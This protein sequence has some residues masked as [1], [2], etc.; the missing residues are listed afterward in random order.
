MKR[1]VLLVYYVSLSFKNS[2]EM[3]KKGQYLNRILTLLTWMAILI[4]VRF[5]LQTTTFA[6]FRVPTDS[7]QPTLLPGDNILV[8]KSIMGA[9]IFDIW[10]ATEG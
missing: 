7:M 1:C 9:R 2:F 3:N 5:L 4:V 6:T 10:E 8:N